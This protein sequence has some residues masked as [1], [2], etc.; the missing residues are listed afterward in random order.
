M[1]TTR[2]VYG[3]ADLVSQVTPYRGVLVVAVLLMLGS[4]L[5]GLSIPWMAGNLTQALTDGQQPLGLPWAGFLSLWLLLFA[6]QALLGFCNQYLI[7]RVSEQMLA[8]LRSCLYEHLQALP[9]SYHHERK[10]GEILALMSNDAANINNF[11]THTLVG[12]LPLLVSFFG[13]LCLIAFI[14]PLTALLIGLFLPLFFLLAKLLGRRIRPLA[15][16]M[17]N[18]YASTFSVVEENLGLLPVI[19]SF[20]R[21][22]IEQTR[23]EQGNQRLFRLTSRHQRIQALLGSVS[24]FLASLGILGILALGIVRIEAGVLSPADLVALLLYAMMLSAPLS[25]LADVYGQVQRARGSAQRLMETFTMAPESRDQEGRALPQVRGKI[26][27]CSVSFAYPGREAVLC[28]LDLHIEAGET[29]AITG[30]NGS[31]KSTLAH[32]LMRFHEPR[33]GRILIDGVDISQVTLHSLRS[34]IG[35]VQQQVLLMNGSVRDNI[36]FGKPGATPEDIEAAAR[37]AHALE[38]IRALPDGFDTL[39]GDH[40]VRLSGGQKQRLSLAQALLKDPPIL[41][42]DEATAMFDPDGEKSFIAECHELLRRRTVLLITHRPESLKLADR[43][44]VMRQGR[45][46]EPGHQAELVGMGQ[47]RFKRDRV[48]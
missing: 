25:G 11:V 14:D 3:F 34:Q 4:S 39:I 43:V 38:F 20:T 41:I 42:L 19:K 8:R 23:F 46:L 6:L 7:A 18:A 48:T 31:G 37:A 24:R 45:L 9:L 17:I 12:L 40:G 27:F 47:T 35:L 16:E 13:A 33:S 21:E 30:S 36:A 32:L 15:H 5:A 44:L 28:D 22:A 29:L 2:K 10:R 1:D 26:D